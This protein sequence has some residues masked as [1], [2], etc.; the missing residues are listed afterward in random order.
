MAQIFYLQGC[1]IQTHVNDR[2][3]LK[4]LVLFQ[5]LCFLFCILILLLDCNSMTLLYLLNQVSLIP[6]NP[7][8]FTCKARQSPIFPESFLIHAQ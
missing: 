6:L 5:R 1:F 4:W 2:S 7:N 8:I 3:R